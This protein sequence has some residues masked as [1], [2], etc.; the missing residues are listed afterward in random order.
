MIRMVQRN[1]TVST[2]QISSFISQSRSTVTE[3]RS[4]IQRLVDSKLHSVYQ[5]TNLSV[6]TGVPSPSLPASHIQEGRGGGGGGPGAWG[7]WEQV[8]HKIEWENRCME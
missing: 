8:I 6:L 2:H 4:S 3:K 1:V 5:F 7:K